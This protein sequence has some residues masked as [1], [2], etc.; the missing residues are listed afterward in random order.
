MSR[1]FAVVKTIDEIECVKVKP[2]GFQPFAGFGKDVRQDTVNVHR[3]T[4]GASKRRKPGELQSY[5]AKPSN[6]ILFHRPA[7]MG[8][9]FRRAVNH[10]SSHRVTLAVRGTWILIRTNW[11]PRM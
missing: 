4:F 7:S 6:M 5:L 1:L 10:V 3:A 2:L 11:Q 8:L 9:G